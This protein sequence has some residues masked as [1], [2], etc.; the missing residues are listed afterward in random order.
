[1]E[2]LRSILRDFQMPRTAERAPVAGFL[3]RFST[4][5]TSNTIFRYAI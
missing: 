5:E 4:V 3:Q 1:M 2:E